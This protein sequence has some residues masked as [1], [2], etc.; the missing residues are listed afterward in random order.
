MDMTERNCRSA[1]AG[2]ESGS[3]SDFEEDLDWIISLGPSTDDS[4]SPA[5]N[6][7]ISTI[8]TESGAKR[9][10]VPTATN[11]DN[12]GTSVEARGLKRTKPG[13]QNVPTSWVPTC[14]VNGAPT[15]RPEAVRVREL[16]E[17]RAGA[18]ITAYIDDTHNLDSVQ[19]QLSDL[20]QSPGSYDPAQFFGA[21]DSSCFSNLRDNINQFFTHD[22][23]FKSFTMQVPCI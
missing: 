10:R 15:T 12:S 14:R 20:I 13:D 5:N 23:T 7:S 18:L 21:L 9:K 2:S 1:E 19:V 17:A 6:I 3:E 4:R 8:V 22:C 11:N 16:M